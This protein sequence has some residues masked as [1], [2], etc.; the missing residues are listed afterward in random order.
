MRSGRLEQVA[1]PDELYSRPATAFVAEFVGT[2]NRLPGD[3]GSGGKS[4]GI[5]GVTVPV[6]EGGPAE[7]PVDALVRPENLNVT[8]SETGNG[9]VTVRTFLGAVTRLAVRLSGDTEVV[10]DVATT[11]AADM[12]PGTAVQVGLPPAPVLVAAHEE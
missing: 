1:S 9:I 12:T 5:L 10:V 11:S 6:I 4:I 2:M 7:G 8:A 3:L